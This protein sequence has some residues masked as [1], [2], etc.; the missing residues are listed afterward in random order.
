MNELRELTQE[1][2]WAWIKSRSHLPYK[3]KTCG[4]DKND[5]SYCTAGQYQDSS[6]LHIPLHAS[7]GAVRMEGMRIQHIVTK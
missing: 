3:C 7:V 5:A 6:G 1:E 2:V 4:Y